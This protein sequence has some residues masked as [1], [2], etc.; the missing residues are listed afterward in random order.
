MDNNKTFSISY[1]AI[2]SEFTD[3]SIDAFQL[4]ESI[5]SVAEM[6]DK[7]D[8]VLNGEHSTVKV[9]VNAPAKEGSLCVDFETVQLVQNAVDVVKTLGLAG[10]SAATFGGTALSLV[11]QLQ[12]KK[13]LEVEEDVNNNSAVITLKDEVINCSRDVAKLVT[14]PTIR[15][16]MHKLIDKPL[17]GKDSPIFKI[18]SGE[19]VVEIEG[20]EISTFT[21]LQ[22]RTLVKSENETVERNISFTQV[23]FSGPTG[24][25][26][27][28]HGETPSVRMEDEAFL[29][30]V[31]GSQAKFSKDD[32]F[33]VK[34][35]VIRT[36]SPRGNTTR[37]IIKEVL[38]HRPADG[39]KIM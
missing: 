13:V 33:V 24:W 1:D 6:I 9:M 39:K 37:Y 15:A 30:R 22:A 32:L 5:H 21:P 17:Y 10:F 23:N 14:D 3:H 8:K 16:A 20:E 12:R 29:T 7:A 34:M 4:A 18:K 2:N 36:E 11:N 25:K 19:E 28:Y 35:D 26:M 27:S 31:K 38:R